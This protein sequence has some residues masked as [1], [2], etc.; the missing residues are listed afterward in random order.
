MEWRGEEERRRG[1]GADSGEERSGEKIS[2]VSWSGVERRRERKAELL[3]GAE[4]R[5]EGERS[6]MERGG[7]GLQW[8]RVGLYGEEWRVV[9]RRGGERKERGEEWN[10]G[11]RRGEER[12]E[13]RGEE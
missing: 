3:K 7:E 11:E 1:E 10:V 2:A 8:R 9:K 4:S 13:G 5:E 12:G 6:G